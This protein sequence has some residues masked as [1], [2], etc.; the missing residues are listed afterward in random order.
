MQGAHV[1][2]FAYAL[3]ACACATKQPLMFVLVRKLLTNYDYTNYDL[4]DELKH[5]LK[6]AFF[7][8][9]L[10]SDRFEKGRKI[11]FLLFVL[12]LRRSGGGDSLGASSFFKKRGFFQLEYCDLLLFLPALRVKAYFDQ[13]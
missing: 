6:Q 7:S 9:S 1:E 4:G 10:L 8:I 11:F 12:K 2:W 13:M 3:M 5:S